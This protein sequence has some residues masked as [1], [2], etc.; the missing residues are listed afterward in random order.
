MVWGCFARNGVECLHKVTGNINSKPN[1]NILEYHLFSMYVQAGMQFFSRIFLL[2]ILPRLL[3]SGKGPQ[4]INSCLARQ[5][6]GH[7]SH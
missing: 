2:A 4:L 5:Q 7:D 1:I 6:R 3:R